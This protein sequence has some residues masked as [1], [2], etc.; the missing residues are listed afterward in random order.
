MEN[1]NREDEW[2]TNWS[3]ED[4]FRFEDTEGGK[5]VAELRA[6][7]VGLFDVPNEWLPE[8]YRTTGTHRSLASVEKQYKREQAKRAERKTKADYAAA[9]ARNVERYAEQFETLVERDEGGTFVR[10]SEGFDRSEIEHDED[11]KYRWEKAFTKAT[12][13]EIE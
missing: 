3:N 2:N 5:I 9:K 4:E 6:D 8:S 12:E 7:V 11:G 13:M 1:V 10:M